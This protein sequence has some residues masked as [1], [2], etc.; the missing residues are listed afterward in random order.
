M[1]C[2]IIAFLVAMSKYTFRNLGTNMNEKKQKE[3]AKIVL[4]IILCLIMPIIGIPYG[5]YLIMENRMARRSTAKEKRRIKIIGLTVIGV[6]FA[7]IIYAFYI[8]YV[9]FRDFTW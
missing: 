9:F 2:F 1:F 4:L 3:T 5:I 6:Y 7:V 8:S